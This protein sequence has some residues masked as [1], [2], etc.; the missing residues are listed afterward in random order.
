[1]EETQNFLN[2]RKVVILRETH[3]LLNDEKVVVLEET[4]YVLNNIGQQAYWG[5]KNSKPPPRQESHRT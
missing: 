4:N 1:M 2:D 3:N 5:K